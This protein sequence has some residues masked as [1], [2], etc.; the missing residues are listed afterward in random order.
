MGTASITTSPEADSAGHVAALAR[1]VADLRVSELPSAVAERARWLL[2]DTVGVIVAGHAEPDM[3]A[4]TIVLGG[5]DEQGAARLLGTQRRVGVRD[6]AFLNAMAGVWHELDEGNRFARG[7]PGIHVVPVVL[8]LGESLGASGARVLEAAVAGYEVA[9]RAGIACRLREGFHPHGI[10]GIL[11][12]AAAAAKLAGADAP[13]ITQALQIAPY[14]AATSAYDT[15]VRGLTVR[16]T[17]AGLGCANGL[18]AAALARAGI[19][20]SPDSAALVF[21]SLLGRQFDGAALLDGLGERFELERGYFKPF[22][23][24]RHTH[25]AIEVL[26]DLYA[27]QPFT[28]SAV[29]RIKVG[30]YGAAA[31][32]SVTDVERPLA[33]RFSIPVM[34]ALLIWQGG[35][36]RDIPAQL[37]QDESFRQLARRIHVSVDAEAAERYPAE[38]VTRVEVELRD[39]RRLAGESRSTLGDPE[40]PLSEQAL[41]TKFL[42]LVEPVLGRPA[43]EAALTAWGQVDTATDVRTLTALLAPAP[44]LSPVGEPVSVR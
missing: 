4:L 26:A 38:R 32:L 2:L 22:A 5:D 7:H 30:T 33:A 3:R 29:G 35:Y 16:N 14:L 34:L 44:I 15:A 10:W 13:A 28:P 25:G 39:G 21:G 12:A 36:T 42:S 23:A 24:C 41:A 11:G 9:A 43:A 27:S 8:A 37:L 17:F 31:E 40:R 20:G 6:A 1:F 19:Q 18:L